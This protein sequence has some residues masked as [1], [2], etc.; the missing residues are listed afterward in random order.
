MDE[1]VSNLVRIARGISRSQ[2][3]RGVNRPE[4]I[5]QATPEL[6]CSIGL[7]GTGEYDAYYRAE[8]P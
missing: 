8:V 6:G 4:S 5:S 7:N 2:P 3:R 1:L